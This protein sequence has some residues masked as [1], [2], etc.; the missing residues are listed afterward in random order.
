MRQ[1][2]T[3]RNAYFGFRISDDDKDIVLWGHGEVRRERGKKK[4]EEDDEDND[5]D[6][7][8]DIL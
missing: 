1:A 5:K 8:N 6:N 3:R 2:S 7:D 4:R